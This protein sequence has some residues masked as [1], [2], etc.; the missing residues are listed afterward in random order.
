MSKKPRKEK[1]T[2]TPN[3]YMD[4]DK[5]F[6]YVEVEL[7]GVKKEDIE[8]SVSDQSFCVRA[9]REDIEFLGCYVLAHLSDT[10]ATRAKFHDGMLSMEIP[11]KKMQKEKKVVIE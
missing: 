9:D 7:P 4:H 1:P 10:D 6:Y 11:L 2:M 3:A 5:K 8:L